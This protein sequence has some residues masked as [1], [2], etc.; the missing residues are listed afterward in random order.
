MKNFRDLGGNKI[1]DGRIVKKGLFYRFVKLLNLSENDIKIL[2]ELNIKYIFDYRSDEE[3]CKYLLI[4]ILNIKNI[5]ILVMRELEELGGSFGFIED[6]IDG[7]F[8]K[9]G[10][11]NM[12]NNSY[13]NLFINNL[14]YKK[15]VEFIR[16]YF[17]LLILNYCIVGKD[18]IG[19]GSVI[20]FMILGVLRENI[21]KDYLKSNDFVDKEIERFIEY[22]FKFKDI[23]KENLKYI[24]GVNEEYM[25]I[26]FRRIDEEYISVEVY[27][28]GEF[29]LNKEEIRKLRN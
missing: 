27:L 29:N 22:K 19:V 8:E 1:E 18:R 11:F 28:Y 23:L 12:L 26:V 21:M 3:V 15:L 20:I 2:K 6:M 7:L 24:F 25:K 13:Y 4:I 14:L 10:V 5:R 9:D 16:D 17:N